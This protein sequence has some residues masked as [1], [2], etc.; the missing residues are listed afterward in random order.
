LPFR[1][2]FNIQR[3]V[4]GMASFDVISPEG[5]FNI[6][7][8]FFKI[9]YPYILILAYPLAYSVICLLGMALQQ[10]HKI[11]GYEGSV[12]N[13]TCLKFLYKKNKKTIVNNK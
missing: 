13:I 11:K 3:H 1:F 8:V 7:Y 6:L 2:G 5:E 10:I 12:V 9:P 4:A